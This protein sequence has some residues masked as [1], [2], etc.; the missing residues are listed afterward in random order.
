M[1][2]KN[3]EDRFNASLFDEDAKNEGRHRAPI[4]NKK[5]IKTYKKLLEYADT[6]NSD[7]HWK[8]LKEWGTSRTLPTG[9]YIEIKIFFMYE[10]HNKNNVNYFMYI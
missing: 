2:K 4:M 3:L 8:H 7:K 6:F 9:M 5:S 1:P 10:I